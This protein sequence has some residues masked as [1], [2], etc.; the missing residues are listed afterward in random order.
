MRVLVTGGAGFI[1]SRVALELERRG[2]EAVVLDDFS[3]G[4]F[5][6][7]NGFRGGVVTADVSRAQD[8]IYRVGPVDAVTHQAAIT[9]TTCADQ[10][11]M[12]EVNA[13]GWRNVL[14]FAAEAGVRRVVY[15]S[16]AGVYGRGAV[17]MREDSD[18]APAN[19]YAF[20]KR[21]M[22][23]VAADF[24]R[25]NPDMRAVGLRYFNVYGPG[26]SFKGAA[27]SMIW[28]LSRQMLSG[29]RPRVFKW[30]KQFR[31]FVHVQDAV[32]A[33]LAALERGESG[34]YNV[35][36]GAGTSFNRVIELLNAALGTSLEP[37]Y[38][39][40]P[41][42]FYQD[43]TQGD[44]ARAREALGFQASVSVEQGLRD[45][46]APRREG[47]ETPAVMGKAA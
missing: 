33:N 34:A 28:Q 39:D 25:E 11:R 1:G 4:H 27:A 16:S 35:C 20:S 22:E 19:V 31:D 40:N 32:A 10:R 15:A 44:P 7:L 37:E 47:A 45:Y 23:R 8:W 38:F 21:V 6:N 30:G 36:T 13:E 14:S 3:K 46:V 24:V 26:E 9:D 18:P 43:E 5:E 12:L 41:H 2:H 17:P 42:G 29:K